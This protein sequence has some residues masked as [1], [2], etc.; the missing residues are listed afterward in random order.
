MQIIKQNLE[1]I[2]AELRTNPYEY[3]NIVTELINYMKTVL[4]IDK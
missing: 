3:K 2:N 1:I 4:K